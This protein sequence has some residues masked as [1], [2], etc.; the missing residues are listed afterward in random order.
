MGFITLT[1]IILLCLLF[2]TTRNFGF[3]LF[4]LLFLTYPLTV[5]ALVAIAIHF[6]NRHTIER[7][8]HYEPPTLPRSH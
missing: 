5:I 1:V 8:T 3:L 2:D 4:I 6:I 7:T